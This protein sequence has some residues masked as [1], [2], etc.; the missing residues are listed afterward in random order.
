MGQRQPI[1]EMLRD[2]ALDDPLRHKLQQVQAIRHFASNEL[3]LPDNGSYLSYAAVDRPALVWSVVATREFSMQPKQWC[4]LFIGCASYRGYFSRQQAEAYADQLRAVG[5]DV[6]IEP[7]PAYSTLGWFDDPLPSTVIHWPEPRLAGLIF[8]ELAHQQL[9]VA[10]D[11]AFNEGFATLVA[12]VGVERWLDGDLAALGWWRKFKQ[13]E[14]EF[15]GLLLE[16]RDRL[17][18][19]YQ[20]SLTVEERRARKQYLFEQLRPR[21][22]DLKRAWDGFTGFD[23]WFDRPLNN[24]HLASIAT[25]QTWVPAFRELLQQVEG[26]LPRFYRASEELGALP[27][28]RRRGWMTQWGLGMDG[29]QRP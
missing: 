6:A 3:A 13:R 7:V 9:Y 17:S 15:I 14:Q 22:A 23:H 2:P 5:L 16:T 26:D 27:V 24:A 19:L 1:A 8:H 11:S 28:G 29:E 25:Y 4:Y 21:Y 10:D 20:Q 12:E 18:Q